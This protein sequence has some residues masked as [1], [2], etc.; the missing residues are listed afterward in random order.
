MEAISAT[1][2]VVETSRDR[3]RTTN[4]KAV[5]KQTAIG[6]GVAMLVMML[7]LTLLSSG[8]AAQDNSS[9]GNAD[10][11]TGFCSN[12]IMTTITNATGFITVLGPTAGILNAG[13]NMTK[14]A[15]TN[16]SN[17]KKEAKEN[18]QDSIK[19]GFGVGMLGAIAALLT[20]FGPFAVC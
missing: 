4:W 16:K 1:H 18:I 20:G 14:A 8:V 17:K 12:P 10:Q 3:V 13:W 5:G 7:T 19:Y 9:V 2:S 15:S 11:N 6:V